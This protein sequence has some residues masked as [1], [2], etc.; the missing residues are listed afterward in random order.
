MLY[1]ESGF[2]TR[3]FYLRMNVFNLPSF[4][5]NC[6]ITCRYILSKT[7][8][9][10]SSEKVSLSQLLTILNREMLARLK[11]WGEKRNSWRKIEWSK[12]KL[13]KVNESWFTGK[14]IKQGWYMTRCDD[15]KR[16]EWK[17]LKCVFHQFNDTWKVICS[18]TRNPDDIVWRYI[19]WQ[20]SCHFQNIIIAIFSCPL[21]A[22]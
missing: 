7:L 10:S 22:L 14:D 20:L 4:S 12:G 8:I 9:S 2:L 15:Y 21:T 16:K 6:C 19:V 3:Y 17:Q 13:R 1:P 18:Y 5:F 11:S